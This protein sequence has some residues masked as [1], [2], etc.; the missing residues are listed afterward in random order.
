MSIKRLQNHPGWKLSRAA[1][2]DTL[3][4]KRAGYSGRMIQ[5]GIDALRKT[6]L[7]PAKEGL[8][9]GRY[10]TMKQIKEASVPNA[11]AVCDEGH[12]DTSA[13]IERADSP[14]TKGLLD[15]DYLLCRPCFESLISDLEKDATG[16]EVIIHIEGGLV[17]WVALPNGPARDYCVANYD[18]MVVGD[19]S[20]R[21]AYLYN[22]LS[23]RKPGMRIV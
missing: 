10:A 21:Q 1:I 13:Y 12:V 20:I 4:A 8:I 16:A 6:Q 17:Q 3:M 7:A 22:F 5:L 2:Q 9:A 19:A 11:C 18:E 15:N 23:A 14:F